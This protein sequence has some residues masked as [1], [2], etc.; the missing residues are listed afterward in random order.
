MTYNYAREFNRWTAWKED[1]EASLRKLGVDE[2]I[3]LELR[4]YDWEIFK[5]ERSFRR[6]QFITIDSFFLN[7]P[8][9]D[10]KDIYNLQNLLD[11]IDDEVLY[12]F[13]RDLDKV[14]LTIILFKILG[15]KT[16]DI[17]RMLNLS[18]S[19]IRTRM[20]RMRKKLKKFMN[21]VA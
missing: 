9:E 13:L 1:E 6:R 19:S 16:S 14:T 8:Y 12:E 11:A 5:K 7:T 21:S 4:Q 10:T 18:N 2:H 17:A 20:S 15:Y 3:I